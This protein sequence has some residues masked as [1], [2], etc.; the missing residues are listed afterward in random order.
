MFAHV[1]ILK[2]EM[3]MDPIHDKGLKEQ[4]KDHSTWVFHFKVT[5]AQSQNERRRGG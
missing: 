3:V 5:H 4:T 2:S 1:T